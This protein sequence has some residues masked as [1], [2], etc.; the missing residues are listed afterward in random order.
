MARLTKKR[1]A[2]ISLKAREEKE[3][4]TAEFARLSEQFTQFRRDAAKRERMLWEANAEMQ[5][6]L[7]SLSGILEG[8]TRVASDRFAPSPSPFGG[9]NEMAA[10]DRALAG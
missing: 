4:I 9:V 5:G 7:S 2:E 8:A 3:V 1:M 10:P 6:R